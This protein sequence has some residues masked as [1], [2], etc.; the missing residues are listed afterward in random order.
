MNWNIENII[1]GKTKGWV[2]AALVYGALCGAMLMKD[3]GWPGV[4]A[5]LASPYVLYVMIV[6]FNLW[7]WAPLPF[8][9][10]LLVCLG[11]SPY[12]DYSVGAAVAKEV[13]PAMRPVLAAA[14]KQFAATRKYPARWEDLGIPA[15]TSRILKRI[16]LDGATGRISVALDAYAFPASAP[17]FVPR[18]DLDAPKTLVFT[19]APGAGGK[20]IWTCKSPDMSPVYLPPSCKD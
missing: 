19:R 14:E 2:L 15:P 13:M 12:R 9:V 5:G 7:D 18:D 16:T 17:P 8:V 6:L 3:F 11:V 20:L 1:G 4:A 10:F